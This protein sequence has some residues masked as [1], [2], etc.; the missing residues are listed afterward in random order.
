MR[1]LF[2]YEKPISVANTKTHIPPILL[3]AKHLNS[4]WKS[5]GHGIVF[6][7]PHIAAANTYNSPST[8]VL[9]HGKQ[10]MSSSNAAAPPGGIGE[11]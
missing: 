3:F 4:F 11:E 7:K 9:Q 10:I 2:E 8:A 1:G 6:L 5:P